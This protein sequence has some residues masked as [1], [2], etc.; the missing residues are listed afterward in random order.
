MTHAA[1][2]EQKSEA[3]T[4]HDAGK[5]AQGGKGVAPSQLATLPTGAAATANADADPTPTA[6]GQTPDQAAAPAPKDGEPAA[7]LVADKK[8]AAPAHD[9]A[10]AKTA[11]TDTSRSSPMPR[12]PAATT[13]SR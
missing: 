1:P 7:A 2:G 12:K 10:A 6:A 5:G 13:R 11:A 8:P 9:A 4:G 3:V